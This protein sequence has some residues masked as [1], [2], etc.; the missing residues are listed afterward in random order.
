MGFLSILPP[1]IAVALAFLT[2]NTILSLAVACIIGV[3]LNGGGLLGFPDLLKEALG[4]EDFAWIFL[5]ELFIGILI[6]FFQRTGAIE[7]V[8]SIAERRQLSKRKVEI[9]AWFMGMFV[10]FSDSFSPVFVGTTMRKIT[11]RVRISR[12][13][14]AYICDSTSAPM[15]VIVPF[16]GWAVF[17]AG[18]LMGMGP[19]H[20][21]VEAMAVFTK[22][23]PFNFYAI[24]S[25]L[26]VGL[27]AMGWIKDFGP[28]RK[29]EERAEKE[30]KVIRDGSS[31]L[32]SKELTNIQPY[33]EDRI[34]SVW[35]NFL[36][37][38]IVIISIAMGSYFFMGTTKTM[39]AFL[40]AIVVLGIAM[41]LQGIPTSDIMD[42][43][44]NG[45]KG[46]MP[47]VMILIFAYTI[48]T[49][50]EQMGTAEYL[51]GATEA[52]L[53]PSLLPALTFILAALISFSTGS[54]WGTYGIMIPIAVPVAFGFADGDITT[55]VLATIAAVA[56]GGVFGDHC[57]PLSDTTILASTGAAVDHIDHVRTQ[58]PYCLLVG[59]IGLI[60]YVALGFYL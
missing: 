53:S 17:I 43:A 12:E 37:P 32:V 20:G 50:S 1:F 24:F 49:L 51:I 11:D 46:I 44:I 40:A 48:N 28:M 42:T 13:K 55:L 41:R 29:A 8:A 7:S 52:W 23:I 3:F 57:S 19:I 47:A 25:I 15:A 54:S 56:G 6:A 27:I 36:L 18:L 21:E 34:L 58:I 39:E 35:V 14:L 10:F 16:T 9:S 31:P 59:L 5:L 22:S 26:L 4:N 33:Y 2:R 30:G 38:V 60:I 45:I